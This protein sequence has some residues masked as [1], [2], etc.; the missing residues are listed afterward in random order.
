MHVKHIFLGLTLTQQLS[1]LGSGC[2]SIGRAAASDSRGPHFESSHRQK[3]VMNIFRNY[4][5]K[6]PRMA[7]F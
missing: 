5:E 3:F 7:H 1:A 4:K 6:R 2:G